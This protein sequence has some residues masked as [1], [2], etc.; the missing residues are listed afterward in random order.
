[1]ADNR[2][3]FRTLLRLQALRWHEDK[4][5]HFFPRIAQDEQCLRLA[6]LVMQVIIGL[7]ER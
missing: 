6:R 3:R 1:V 5:R 7:R 4:L 2:F